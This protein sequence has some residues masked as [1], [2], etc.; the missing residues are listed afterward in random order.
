MFYSYISCNAYDMQYR[1]VILAYDCGLYNLCNN[2][3]IRTVMGYFCVRLF[4]PYSAY[5]MR[6]YVNHVLK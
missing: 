2:G 5:Y 1:P 4:T 3:C 6:Q